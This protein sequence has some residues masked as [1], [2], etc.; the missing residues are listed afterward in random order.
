MFW[1]VIATGTRESTVYWLPWH[2]LKWLFQ[3][4]GVSTNDLSASAG[5]WEIQHCPIFQ[6]L[7]SSKL[8]QSEG[9]FFIFLFFFPYAADNLTEGCINPYVDIWVMCFYSLEKNFVLFLIKQFC[10]IACRLV[11][12][13]ILNKK[14]LG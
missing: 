3:L 12:S 13:Q 1:N 14:A 5:G 4:G 10:W 11:S 2:T 6:Q 8:Y 7:W 9:F